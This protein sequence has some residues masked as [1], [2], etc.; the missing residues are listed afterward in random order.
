MTEYC[1][2]HIPI[3]CQLEVAGLRDFR[4]RCEDYLGLP[5]CKFRVAIPTILREI[6]WHLCFDP[7]MDA[8]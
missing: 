7:V 4:S 2:T 3:F 1:V 8:K 5:P 6:T